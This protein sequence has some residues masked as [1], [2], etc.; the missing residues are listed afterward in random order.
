MNIHTNFCV[1]LTL[2]ILFFWEIL[3]LG[4][5]N[6]FFCNWSYLNFKFFL[7]FLS[8]KRYFIPGLF[9]PEPN[10]PTM[11]TKLHNITGKQL[12]SATDPVK[13]SEILQSLLNA[14]DL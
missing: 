13:F 2:Q 11:S 3:T 8:P 5:T 9:H 14:G 6:Y 12:D 4:L 10:L 1:E 7:G